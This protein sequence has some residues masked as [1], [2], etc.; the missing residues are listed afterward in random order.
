[1]ETHFPN[2]LAIYFINIVIKLKLFGNRRGKPSQGL[3][4]AETNG[5]LILKDKLASGFV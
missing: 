1:M 4:L 5:D 2:N 3:V